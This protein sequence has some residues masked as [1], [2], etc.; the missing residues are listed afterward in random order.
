MGQTPIVMAAYGS[1]TASRAVYN[2]LERVVRNEFGDHPLFWAGTSDRVR[3]LARSEGQDFFPPPAVVLEQLASQGMQGA[4]V[5][6]L[7]LLPAAGYVRLRHLC[8]RARLATAVG[9][10]LLYTPD[11]YG[12]LA[13]SLAPLIKARPGQ[14]ILLVGHGTVHPAWTAFP[15]LELYLRRRFGRRVFVGVV[16]KFPGGAHEVVARM[17]ADDHRRVCLIPFLLTAGMHF[18]RDLVGAGPDS[19][20]SRLHRAGLEVELIQEG[21]GLLPGIAEIFCAHIRQALNHLEPGE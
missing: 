3:E 14:A 21:I 2:H 8:S 4:V 18:K 1:T 6:S 20:G 15:A 17:V 16:E 7:H 13:D 19:W 9:T 5:Q 11:D 10:P 12:A